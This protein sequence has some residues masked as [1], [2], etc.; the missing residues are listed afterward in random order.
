MNLWKNLLKNFL[1]NGGV[2]NNMAEVKILINGYAKKINDNEYASCSVTLIRDN[3]L[4]ILVDTGMDRKLLLEAIKKEN[5]KTD[6]INFV[7][8]THT[9]IDH[10]ILAGIFENAQIV[11]N[12]AVYSFD[13]KITEHDGKIPGTE[14]KI[15]STPGHD[16]FHCT[17][18][19]DTNQYGKVAIAADVFWWPDG[20]EQKTDY[21]SLINLE[22]EY[23]KDKAVL[24]ESRK[25]VLEIADY[26][27]PGHGKPF[28]V[29][30]RKRLTL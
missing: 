6:D 3:N 30:P 24:K 25:K 8:L 22:D 21:E 19:V 23:M 13:G 12:G 17:V 29:M 15:I 18:L 5:L 1:M 2:K 28:R 9:H 14:I 26:I 11:D 27:I 10:C 20:A 4:N 16:Q 7:V